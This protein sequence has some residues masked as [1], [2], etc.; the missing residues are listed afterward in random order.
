MTKGLGWIKTCLVTLTLSLT[1]GG[2]AILARQDNRRPSAPEGRGDLIDPNGSGPFLDLPPL[3]SL[4]PPTSAGLTVSRGLAADPLE[5][6]P[7]P[8][9]TAPARRLRPI[10]RTRSSR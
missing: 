9:L 6:P 5:L 10:A 1:M 3:P 8:T 2:W 7:I 4:P